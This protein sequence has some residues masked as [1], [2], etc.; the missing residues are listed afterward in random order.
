M[1]PGPRQPAPQLLTE[2]VRHFVAVLP[3]LGC[4]AAREAYA[5]ARA[6][7]DA[8][9]HPSVAEVRACDGAVSSWIAPPVPRPSHSP[10]LAPSALFESIAAVDLR[11]HTAHSWAYYESALRIAHAACAIDVYRNRSGARGERAAYRLFGFSIL[12]LF[13]LFAL[14]LGLGMNF[15]SSHEACKPGIDF[16]GKTLLR[17]GVALL[18]ARITLDNIVSLGWGPVAIVLIAVAA[19]IC[20]SVVAAKLAGFNPL[21]GLLSG[22]ATAICGAS[23]A[24]ALSAAL[25]QHPLKERATE[26]MEAVKDPGA[27]GE[28]A[29]KA[30]T[31]PAPPGA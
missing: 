26:A 7:I 16:A 21:F 10:L 8:D 18:G 20:I 28:D 13:M 5:I 19:T 30:A 29:P 23:A 14:L 6:V 31:P 24:L 2:A 25:P 4:D 27:P 15:L 3:L 12:Y 17:L 11:R 22:G 1:Q 9:G